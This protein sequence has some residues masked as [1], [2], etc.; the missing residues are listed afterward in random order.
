MSKEKVERKVVNE[1]GYL[2]PRT[3]LVKDLG[4]QVDLDSYNRCLEE[5]KTIRVGG[6]TIKIS[7]GERVYGTNEV[8]KAD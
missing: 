7:P 8:Y 4:I 5:T 3:G 6:I 2:N 1:V